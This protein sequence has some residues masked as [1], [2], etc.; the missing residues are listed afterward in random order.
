M[1]DNKTSEAFR[2]L[3]IELC[4]GVGKVT[5]FIISEKNIDGIVL[6]LEKYQKMEEALKNVKNTTSSQP[7]LIRSIRRI[8]NEALSFDPLS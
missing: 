2:E 3:V 1:N 4:S 8:C 6:I 5:A 7:R